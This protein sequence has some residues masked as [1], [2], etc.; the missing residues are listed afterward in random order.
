MTFELMDISGRIVD[1]TA[2]LLLVVWDDAKNVSTEVVAR[3]A[4]GDGSCSFEGDSPPAVVYA[5]KEC[6]SEI[7]EFA[8]VLRDDLRE[9]N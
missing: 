8:M 1:R 5:L 3:Y 6:I 2:R 9:Q 7:R 4:Y